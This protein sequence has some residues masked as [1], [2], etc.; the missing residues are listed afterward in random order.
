MWM[1]NL[2]SH[3]HA[4]S[5]SLKAQAAWLL[6]GSRP[7]STATSLCPTLEE[8]AEEEQPRDVPGSSSPGSSSHWPIGTH[9][10]ATMSVANS[11]ATSDRK[12]SPPPG[13]TAPQDHPSNEGRDIESNGSMRMR[14]IRTFMMEN[15]DEAQASA[16]LTAYCFMTGFMYVVRFS[17]ILPF[18]HVAPTQ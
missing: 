13:P 14:S 2:S 6:P 9:S 1:E 3:F 8:E 16:P 10:Q 15:I 17:P 7:I 4:R 11:F 12:E 5:P 18:A